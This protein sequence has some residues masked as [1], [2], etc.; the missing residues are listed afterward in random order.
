MVFVGVN[1]KGWVH[2]E[3]FFAQPGVDGSK[4][5]ATHMILSIGAGAAT[6]DRNQVYQL[7]QL[8]V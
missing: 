4:W 3:F 7:D 1:I 2:P 5:Q 8:G 6:K